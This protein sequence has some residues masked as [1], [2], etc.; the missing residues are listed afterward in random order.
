MLKQNEE[1]TKYHLQVMD[2]NYYDP[3]NFTADDVAIEQIAH[4]LA[5]KNRWNGNTND[6]TPSCRPIFYSVAQHSCIVH[7]IA[8]RHKTLFVERF[9]WSVSPDP[10]FYGLMHDAA[11]A[12]LMDVP[13]P[14]KYQPQMEWFRKLE[15][16][17]LFTICQ[18]YGVRVPSPVE[19]C[20]RRIDNAMI[21]WERDALVGKPEKPYLN[22]LDHPGGALNDWV[23]N[24][25]PWS[26]IR[27]KSEFLARFEACRDAL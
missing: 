18:K 1:L 8:S 9:D 24:F 13:R 19:E 26:P 27:A 5:L 2:G 23:G 4:Q 10:A 7:D 25:Q 12:Y 20:V 14:L 16:E 6:L 17:M 3:L 22:E 21:F 11:E 15:D